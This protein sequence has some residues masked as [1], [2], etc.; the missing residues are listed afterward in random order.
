MQEMWQVSV[1]VPAQFEGGDT[2]VCYMSS[3]TRQTQFMC[4][5]RHQAFLIISWQLG[6]KCL[7]AKINVKLPK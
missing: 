3:V 1:V 7:M 2:W 6:L 4:S 5:D